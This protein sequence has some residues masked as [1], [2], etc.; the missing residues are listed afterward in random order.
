MRARTCR[1]SSARPSQNRRPCGQDPQNRAPAS[2]ATG[3]RR[4]RRARVRTATRT[5]RHSPSARA[6]KSPSSSGTRAPWP[7]VLPQPSAAL[8]RD[9]RRYAR[10]WPCR[11]WPGTPSRSGRSGVPAFP[12]PAP[13][14]FGHAAIR[15][16]IRTCHRGAHTRPCRTSGLARSAA[17]VKVVSALRTGDRPWPADM[18]RLS[19]F[20]QVVVQLMIPPRQLVHK[21]LRDRQRK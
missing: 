14:T 12:C 10:R 7:H 16:A 17:G 4:A 11:S 3:M 19:H 18:D 2:V 13:E 15:T 21:R 8:T 1:H 5:L 20:A 6:A 9:I